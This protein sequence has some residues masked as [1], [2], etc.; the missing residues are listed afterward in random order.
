MRK[1]FPLRRAALSDDLSG[2]S[3]ALAASLIPSTLRAAASAGQHVLYPIAA[4]Q[5]RW[6]WAE[7]STDLNQIK[8]SG[9]DGLRRVEPAVLVSRVYS[10]RFAQAQSRRREG[11]D[12]PDSIAGHLG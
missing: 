9:S 7:A 3:Q 6:L 4:F 8:P 11:A 1:A 5:P 12:T 2:V 10:S